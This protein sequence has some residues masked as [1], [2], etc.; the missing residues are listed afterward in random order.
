MQ[1][2]RSSS[3]SRRGRPA[4]FGRPSKAVTLTLPTDV[5]EALRARHP[6]LAWAIVALAEPLVRERS[7]KAKAT[8][9]QAI[10]LVE[11][12]NHQAL[13]LLRK[14]LLR[15][16]PRGVTTIPVADGRVLIDFGGVHGIAELEL[17]ILDR[18]ASPRIDSATRSALIEAREVFR[19]LRGDRKVRF[20]THS[21][22]VVEG[23]AQRAGCRLGLVFEGRKARAPVRLA[24]TERRTDKALRAHQNL[25]PPCAADTI[26]P[27]QAER[28]A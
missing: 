15:D 20:T 24:T 12:P 21:I 10:E 25:P 16:L 2:P 6:D 9:Q 8:R 23:V 26:S 13:I 17:A 11:L 22:L 14:S 28:C 18:L 19:Q 3:R 7:R 4:K 27:K 5:I 1:R